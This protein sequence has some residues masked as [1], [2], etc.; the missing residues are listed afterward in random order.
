MMMHTTQEKLLPDQGERTPRSRQFGGLGPAPVWSSSY[1]GSAGSCDAGDPVSHATADGSEG[2]FWSQVRPGDDAVNASLASEEN[3][4]GVTREALDAPLVLNTS[5][6]DEAARLQAAADRRTRFLKSPTLAT[7][8]GKKNKAGKKKKSGKAPM[9][10]KGGSSA[11]ISIS[12]DDSME[13]RTNSP[14][15]SRRERRRRGAKQLNTAAEEAPTFTS[16]AR[17][18]KMPRFSNSESEGL[19]SDAEREMDFEWCPKSASNIVAVIQNKAEE[20]KNQVRRCGNLKGVYRRDF[21]LFAEEVV[22]A[23]EALHKCVEEA[24]DNSLQTRMHA[25]EH[26]AE[27]AQARLRHLEEERS[28]LLEEVRHLRTEGMAAGLSPPLP[29]RASVQE[30]AIQTDPFPV[31]TSITALPAGTV[32]P[33]AI[34]PKVQGTSKVIDGPRVVEKKSNVDLHATVKSIVAEEIKEVKSLLGRILRGASETGRGRKE[35]KGNAGAQP[36]PPMAGP[37]GGNPAPWVA[38]PQREQ[39]RGRGARTT[40]APTGNPPGGAP[41]SQPDAAPSTSKE[42]GEE[43]AVVTRRRVKAQQ[44]EGPARKKEAVSSARRTSVR[45]GAKERDPRTSTSRL[46][47]RLRSQGRQ[48]PQGPGPRRRRRGRPAAVAIRCVAAEGEGEQ[49]TYASVM[50]LAKE[51]VSLPT[52]GIEDT[53][54]RRDVGGGILVEIPGADGATKADALAEALAPILQGKASVTRPVRRGEIRIVGLD[55]SVSPADIEDRISSGDFGPC[56]RF[57]VTVGPITQGRDR[58]GMT[59]ACC[60]FEVAAKLANSGRL[61]VGWSSA[62]VALLPGRKL[63]CFKCLEFGHVRQACRNEVDRTGMCYRCGKDGHLARN[64]KDVARCVLCAD[65]SLPSGHR[66]GGDS[67]SS[68][69]RGR[70]APPKGSSGTERRTVPHGDEPMETEN[71]PGPSN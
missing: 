54:I 51:G 28:R 58:L 36:T 21:N 27:Q 16:N 40:P 10:A 11:I 57:E 17:K 6:D 60:P 67:C 48:P 2:K 22:S 35:E 24:G 59:W 49:A 53:R 12:D 50:R 43:R 18:R 26:E 30:M 44:K 68:Q 45:D 34:R 13:S 65:R 29:G 3:S 37:L 70:N 41:T 8:A 23:V 62:R 4:R 47:L 31:I 69:D 20:F 52:L 5:S 25:A 9:A 39:G 38:L 71:G 46:P 61:K 19:P 63:Q 32:I 1:E 14:G 64:C 56:R 33:P 15:P 7:V 55:M 66:I 42:K